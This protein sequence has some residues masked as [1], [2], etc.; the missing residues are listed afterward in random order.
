[1]YYQRFPKLVAISMKILLTGSDS[2]DLVVWGA[3][4]KYWLL[5]L[6]T[7]SQSEGYSSKWLVLGTPEYVIM[8][9]LFYMEHSV[10]AAYPSST[11]VYPY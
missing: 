3:M 11:V 5:N 8:I 1:M 4:A 10:A 9:W 6:G 2:Q 7:S